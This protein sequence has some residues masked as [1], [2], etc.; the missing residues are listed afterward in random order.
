VAQPFRL[1]L[2][3][4]R[5]HL[6]QQRKLLVLMLPSAAQQFQLRVAFSRCFL[7][8]LAAN[9]CGLPT[10]QTARYCAPFR[11]V[12]GKHLSTPLLAC[13]WGQSLPEAFDTQDSSFRCALAGTQVLHEL[14]STHDT[15]K[16]QN[17]FHSFVR[18]LVLLLT[19]KQYSILLNREHIQ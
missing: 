7:S 5:C 2:E 3:P 6:D 19:S 13:R 16:S 4:H 8:S 9:Q 12:S 17:C 1:R 11:L 18:V 15:D 10:P 14:A